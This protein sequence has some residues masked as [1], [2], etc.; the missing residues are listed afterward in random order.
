MSFPLHGLHLQPTPCSVNPNL[1]EVKVRP[2]VITYQGTYQHFVDLQS[3]LAEVVYVGGARNVTPTPRFLPTPCSLNPNLR[4]FVVKVQ[5][6]VTKYRET[7][8][9]L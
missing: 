9:H 3:N 6:V 7:C 5:P 2:V 8:R 1:R 4:E